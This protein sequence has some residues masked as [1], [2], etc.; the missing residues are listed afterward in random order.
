[1]KEKKIGF[2]R[3][4]LLCLFVSKALRTCFLLCFTPLIVYKAIA[5]VMSFVWLRQLKVMG[6]SSP[7]ALC[8]H[9]F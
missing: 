1:M 9:K 6:L 7:Y 2:Q 8:P 5:V 3:V 4:V